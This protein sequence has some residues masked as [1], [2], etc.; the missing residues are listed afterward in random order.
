M[1]QKYRILKD[2]E[3]TLIIV[4]DII[5]DGVTSNLQLDR[6]GFMVF[7]TDYLLTGSSDQFPK[8][9]RNNECFILN[10]D[11]STKKG[12]HWVA[13]FKTNNKL[14]YYDSFNRSKSE[15]SKYWSKR[16]LYK[17][18]KTDRDQSF[19]EK[20]CGSRAFTWLVLMKKYGEKA[21]DV[22]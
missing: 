14:Y 2:Y 5:T 1:T 13:F 3:Q 22:I 8:Y 4:Q 10:T 20:S 11:P 7:G 21:I 12:T 19:E 9:I 18:N 17:A 6:L 15:L 16:R